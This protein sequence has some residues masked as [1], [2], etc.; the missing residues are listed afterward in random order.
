MSFPKKNQGTVF[1][2]CK[3]ALQGMYSVQDPLSAKVESLC[4]F[5]RRTL[6]RSEFHVHSASQDKGR[7]VTFRGHLTDGL[8]TG[9]E[10]K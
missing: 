4:A 1:V 9:V 2:A 6:V 5:R 8:P 10:A 7:I 3:Q